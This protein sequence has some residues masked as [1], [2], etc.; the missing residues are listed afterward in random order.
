MALSMHLCRDLN[1]RLLLLMS[2]ATVEYLSHTVLF[3]CAP[4]IVMY[5][6]P[7]SPISH[8]G[9]YTAIL[10]SSNYIGPLLTC[11]LWM[12]WSQ[13]TIHSKAIILCGLASIGL[14]FFALILCQNF[15]QI[16]AVRIVAGIFTN[17]I[18]VAK[19]EMDETCG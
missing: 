8:V 3:L 6:Y 9:F 2:C 10:S 12:K 15:V 17:V 16:L 14:G 18:P 7:S 5:H 11:S 13:N 1:G 4:L 19:A